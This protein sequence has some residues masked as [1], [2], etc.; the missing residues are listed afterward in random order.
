MSG[1]RPDPCDALRGR[2]SIKTAIRL[3]SPSDRLLEQRKRYLARERPS[4]ALD[5]KREFRH[6]IL[7]D[8]ALDV[9]AGDLDAL[10]ALSDF[11]KCR[12]TIVLTDF[13]YQT[14]RLQAGLP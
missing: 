10:V 5:Q 8:D 11:K 13:R 1:T 9:L 12:P 14:S 4:Q 2:A 7:H 6:G 3:S